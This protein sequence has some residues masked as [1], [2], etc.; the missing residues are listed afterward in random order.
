MH[1]LVINIT[2]DDLKRERLSELHR[3]LEQEEEEEHGDEICDWSC[4]WM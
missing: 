2:T 4:T 1:S 3:Q